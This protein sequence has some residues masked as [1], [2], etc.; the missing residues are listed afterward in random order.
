MTTLHDALRRHFGY[1]SFRP[2][3][4]EIAEASLA[5]HDVLALL[6]TGGG[7]S[8]CYQLPALLENG[9]T[10]VVSPLIALMKDQVDALE[11]NGI[12]ATFLNSSIDPSTAEQRLRAL[13]NGEYRLLYVAPERLVLPRFLAGLAR[14]NLRRIAID[15]AHCVSEWGHDFRPEYRQIASLRHYHPDVPMLA[16]T[17]TAT[18]RVRDDIERF[19]GLRRPRRFVASFNRPNLRYSVFEKRDAVAQLVAWTTRRAG[20]SGIVYVQSRIA[21]EQLAGK[22][23]GAGI[24]ALPYHAGLSSAERARNQ[25]SFVCDEV[26]VIC[27][28]IA[29]GMGIH[30]PNVRYVVHYDVPK[31]IEGYYQETGRAGRDG[32]SSDCALF[33]SGGDA[34]KQ[35]HF[36]RQISDSTERES[37]EKRLAQMLDFAATPH[38]RRAHLLRYFG[39]VWDEVG[40]G[41]C[42]NCLQPVERIDGTVA[43]SKLLSCV[44]RI[45]ACSGFSTGARHVVDVL[46]GNRSEKVV[47]WGH[48]RLSTFG[49]GTEHGKDEWLA[50]LSE[51]LR[52]GCIELDPVHRTLLLTDEGLRALKD[53][54]KFTFAKPRF[55]TKAGKRG[56]RRLPA[57]AATPDDDLFEALRQL[58]KKLADDQ[59]VPPYVV[60]SDA[61]LRE[62]SARKPSTSSAFRQIGGVGDVKLQRY[63]EAFISAIR[64]FTSRASDKTRK[65]KLDI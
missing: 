4:R 36:I 22:L 8:L 32:L 24:S 37:A 25:E 12:A 14:W 34:A 56:G 45:R 3:Q 27:A 17:A 15:E 46:R 11:A 65:G 63:G 7:K 48:D 6:P 49:I 47:S 64:A 26:R 39:E 13:D 9:L 33:F 1:Q 60:F 18:Q 62:L 52:I 58:R 53:E 23:T 20:E 5:G 40:C 55:V 44:Y 21:A 29:F 19:L 41:N 51:L 57:A 31:T 35:R 16:L 50:L 10:L 38:C 28:T 59:G 54:R 30:K 2:L 43:A 61:T 42:D